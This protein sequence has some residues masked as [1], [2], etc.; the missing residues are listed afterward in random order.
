MNLIEIVI[1]FFCGFGFCLAMVI[2]S[3]SGEQ[4]R[5]YFN[6]YEGGEK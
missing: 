4:P 3:V 5:N 1:S 2:W 6:G